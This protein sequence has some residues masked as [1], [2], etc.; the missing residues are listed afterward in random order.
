MINVLERI[1][2]ER[3]YLI[4]TKAVYEKP[5]ANIILTGEKLEAILPK[6]RRQS[7]PYPH[8]FSSRMAEALTQMVR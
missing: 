2:L 3:A 7:C 1:G 5:I 6:L 4:V 8:S